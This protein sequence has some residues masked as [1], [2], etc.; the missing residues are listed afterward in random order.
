M[1]AETCLQVPLEVRLLETKTQLRAQGTRRRC[2][3]SMIMLKVL[4]GKELL[5][6]TTRAIQRLAIAV[7][8]MRSV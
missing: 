7:T 5:N 4:P 2:T 6:M 8:L 1:L 3:I